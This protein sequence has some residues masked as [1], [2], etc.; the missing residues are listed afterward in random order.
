[1]YNWYIVRCREPIASLGG[2]SLIMY[3]RWER[4]DV[5]GEGCDASRRLGDSESH[6][7]LVSVAIGIGQSYTVYN[8]FGDSTEN[9][10][11][12]DW[13]DTN[14]V[15]KGDTVDEG[16]GLIVLFGCCWRRSSYSYLWRLNSQLKQLSVYW[17]HCMKRLLN[18]VDKGANF[19]SEDN[20]LILRGATQQP[21]WLCC[22]RL[23]WLYEKVDATG[24][25]RGIIWLLIAL[26][27]GCRRIPIFCRNMILDSWG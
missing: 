3:I 4:T 9:L 14:A 12:G 20:L 11:I 16:I 17:N 27:G 26:I 5:I 25:I 18:R 22:G 13:T 6:G 24:K 21:T 19:Y 10:D 2:E 23:I 15:G 1:M 7:L 8:V